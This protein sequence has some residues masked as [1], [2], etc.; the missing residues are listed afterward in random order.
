MGELSFRSITTIADV[1]VEL[2]Y[3][4]VEDHNFSV[5]FLFP[6]P[7]LLLTLLSSLPINPYDVAVVFVLQ[8]NS[9]VFA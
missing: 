7:P 4:V 2:S 9:S 5:F 1:D 3:A 8:I 6:T